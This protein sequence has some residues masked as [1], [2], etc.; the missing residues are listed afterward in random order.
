MFDDE[1]R[2][3]F[4]LVQN[5]GVGSRHQAVL[6]LFDVLSVGGTDTIDLPYEDR[7]RLLEQLVEPGPNWMIPAH[8]VGDGAALLEATRIQG[9]EG[10]MAKRLGSTYRPGKR[11]KDWRKVKNRQRVE[12][13][14]GGFTAG[15][16]NRSGTFGALLVGRPIDD[17]GP[18]TFAGGVGTGFNHATLTTLS[19]RMQR[20]AH[21][22]VP[23]RPSAADR[24]PARRHVDRAGADGRRS[25]S[26]SSPTRASSA[27]PASSS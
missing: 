26:P 3:R 2:L 16:G 18:L 6:Q 25:R 17:G 27:T 12:L 8:R 4:E 5:S 24:V 11:T 1:G 13:T 22:R 19:T 14:I 23:V 20:A 15:D 10:V 9:L 7:R 21:R